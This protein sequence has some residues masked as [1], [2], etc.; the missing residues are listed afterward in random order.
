MTNEHT[1]S[2][3]EFDYR[4]R[5]HPIHLYRSAVTAQWCYGYRPLCTQVFVDAFLSNASER[6]GGQSRRGARHSRRPHNIR[7][8][9]T[10]SGGCCRAGV[11]DCPPRGRAA[12][13]LRPHP[14]PAASDDGAIVAIAAKLR[15]VAYVIVQELM[16]ATNEA[17]ALG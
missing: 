9:P 3:S 6:H 11:A 14:R 1:S 10:G 15:T 17:A 16:I 13:L 2:V 5:A 4:N 7:C 12:R 8:T